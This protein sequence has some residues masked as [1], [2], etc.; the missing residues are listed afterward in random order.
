MA[1]SGL[2][3]TNVTHDNISLAWDASQSTVLQYIVVMREVGKKKF[4]RVT[5]VAGS[6]LSCSLTEGFEQN[7]ESIFRVYAENE[8]IIV[9]RLVSGLRIG[10]CSVHLTVSIPSNLLTYSSVKW[11][12]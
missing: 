2:R 3:V 12:S 9:F 5:K 4:K 7:Q 10:S 6:Q 11:K 1:P 8:V